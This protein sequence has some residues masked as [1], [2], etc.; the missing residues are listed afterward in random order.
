VLFK[1]WETDGSPFSERF[2]KCVKLVTIQRSGSTK[3]RQKTLLTK[4][5][6]VSR[7]K[8]W[9][10]PCFPVTAPRI[11]MGYTIRNE[12]ARNSIGR[13]VE[14]DSRF[15]TVIINDNPPWRMC[16]KKMNFTNRVQSFTADTVFLCALSSIL[17]AFASGCGGGDGQTSVNATPADSPTPMEMPPASDGPVDPAASSSETLSTPSTA[18]GTITLPD[19]FD[20]NNVPPADANGSTNGSKE[21]GL[22]MP[23][24]GD[25]SFAPQREDS[26]KP[27]SEYQF[28][29]ALLEAD[30]VSLK[31][32]SWEEIKAQ[33]T[34]TGKV[35][36]VD[37]WSL[38][39]EPCLKEFPGLVAIDRDMG[40]SVACFAV[41]S[42]YDGRKTKPAESYR[43][44]VEAFLKSVN[45][46]FP[47]FICTTP[48]EELFTELEIESIPAVLI[49]DAKGKLVRKFVDAGDDAGFTYHDNIVPFIKE[50]LAKQ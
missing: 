18:P 13:R 27:A 15:S 10:A 19:N 49:F 48:N 50:L 20:P 30:E 46:K 22:K 31:A 25:Q 39:C 7:R 3:I 38:A 8:S 47:N 23:P 14:P 33:A 32:A 35:T 11:A 40:D 42:D 36:V 26:L 44:R 29:S 37:V 1:K 12:T 28:T 16:K 4:L 5:V 24:L 34:K 45:A 41:D 17:F 6:F 21:G 43:P 9:F 2:G